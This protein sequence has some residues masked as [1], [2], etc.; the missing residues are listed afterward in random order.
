MVKTPSS[1]TF[2]D[3][4]M[5]MTVCSGI[6]NSNKQILGERHHLFFP[7]GNHGLFFFATTAICYPYL[8]SLISVC[9]GNQWAQQD[10]RSPHVI[11]IWCNS[12][13][14]VDGFFPPKL[15]TCCES[16]CLLSS[17]LLSRRSEHKGMFA[18]LMGFWRRPSPSSSHAR[19]NL[20]PL[21]LQFRKGWI[22]EER[23]FPCISSSWQ[24]RDMEV[25]GYRK[26]DECAA[27]WK[28]REKPS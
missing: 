9:C 7:L 14:R 20:S 18:N 28:E 4:S 25:V 15:E 12:L 1:P 21:R 6:V 23:Y 26:G 19:L 22:R 13:G 24:G 11:Y 2:Y 8:T 3:F 17:C 16:R 27:C 10:G 5:K